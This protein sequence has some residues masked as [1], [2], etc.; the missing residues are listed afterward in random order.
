MMNTNV[1]AT[2]P[3]K[4]N[5]KKIVVEMPESALNEVN[6][7]SL[8]PDGGFENLLNVYYHK[9]CGGKIEGKCNM[10]GPRT[11]LYFR[12]SRCGETHMNLEDFAWYKVN[13]NPGGGPIR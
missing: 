8:L 1:S 7:G 12:C 9:N 2:E 6:G 13:P 3:T 10:V 4:T 5:T 11:P